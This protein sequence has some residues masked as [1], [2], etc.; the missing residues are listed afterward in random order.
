MSD[1]P[2]LEPKTTP[3]LIGHD[4]A[5]K[6]L[7]D[8]YNSGRMHHA[9]LITGPRGIGKATLAYRFARFLL[10]HGKDH[11][12]DGGGLF[13]EALP[14]TEPDSLYVSPEA[15]VFRRLAAGGHADLMT[16]EREFDEKKNRF[17]GQIG[18]DRVRGVGA[19]LGKTSAEGGWRVVVIDAA[20]EMNRNSANAVLKVLEEPPQQAVL[21]LLAHNPGRLL[22]TIRSRCRTLTLN[23]LSDDIIVDLMA[24]H[25]PDSSPDEAL[26]LAKLAEGSFGRALSLYEE[27]GL[28]LHK[29]LVS[30]LAT[31]P[32]LDVEALHKLGDKMARAGADDA[33][34]TLGDLL[35]WWLGRLIS[36]GA[37]A[38]TSGLGLSEAEDA[39][40]LRILHSS[41][42]NK[43]MD[44]WGKIGSLFD[45]AQSGNLDRKQALLNS[46]LALEGAVKR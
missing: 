20:D 6:T 32:Q 27:G 17:K 28:D 2:R 9:W 45:Q 41:D 34:R 37:R 16:I 30:L 24:K 22:P 25:A 35:R 40:M 38:K 19:F 12:E 11:Q 31:L 36:Q 5:E 8:S 46:F 44:V 39:L 21:L 18:V 15:P 14:A 23:S 1:T 13:G 26:G 29:E 33:F 3:D 7:L 42:M 43:L 10:K 4:E